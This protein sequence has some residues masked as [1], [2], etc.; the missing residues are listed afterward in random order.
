MGDSLKIGKTAGPTAKPTGIVAPE[1][2]TAA[3]E[4]SALVLVPP[5]PVAVVEEPQATGAVKLDAATLARLDLLVAGYVVDISQLDV[6]NPKFEE[7][8]SDIRKLGDDEIK[9]SAQVSSRLLE[10]PVGSMQKGGLAASAAVGN[11]LMQLRRQVD[12]LDPGHQGDL[13]GPRKLLGIIPFGDRL[14]SYF[15]RYQSSQG[16]IN[17]VVTGLQHGQTELAKDNEDLEREKVNLW[18]TMERLR[19]YIYLAQK[20]DSSLTS[21]IAEIEAA[22]PERARVLKEDMLFYVRQKVQDLTA[23]LAVSVQGYLSLDVIR[24]NNLE[25]IR[26]VDRATTTT[27][28]ALRT[29][30]IVAQALG[31]QKLVLDQITALNATTS[32]L[33]ESTSVMLHQQ[34]TAINEQAGS[35]TIDVEKLQAA[36]DNIYATMDEIDAFKLKALDSMTKTVDALTT[37]INRAQSYLDRA[38]D[39]DDAA[40]LRAGDKPGPAGP[41]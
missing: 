33:I 36:F 16:H 20:L 9:A 18:Q 13:F 23:Q 19:Q 21:R 4:E 41:N 26:G 11:S 17:A 6:K 27:V 29:A 25:L 24:R 30:V 40:Q 38:K 8:I 35:A 7:R 28:S 14:R 1:A 31:D 32:N 12:A 34:S 5:A 3:P 39:G 10:R 2:D 37:Q 22:D 15:A